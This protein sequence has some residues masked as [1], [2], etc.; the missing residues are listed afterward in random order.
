MLELK[1]QKKLLNPSEQHLMYQQLLRKRK[2]DLLLNDLLLNKTN[3]LFFRQLRQNDISLRQQA[4]AWIGK[5]WEHVNGIC[6]EN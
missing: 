5:R 2:N 6:S 1:L 4:H 3:Q